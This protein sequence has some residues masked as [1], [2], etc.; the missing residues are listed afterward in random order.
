MKNTSGTQLDFPVTRRHCRSLF[1]NLPLL[2]QEEDMRVC[3]IVINVLLMFS[4]FLESDAHQGEQSVLL[5]SLLGLSHE[6]HSS[7]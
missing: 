5:K 7:S 3:H 4:N 1:K 6:F 2:F